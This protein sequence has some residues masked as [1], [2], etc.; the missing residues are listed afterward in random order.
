MSGRRLGILPERIPAAAAEAIGRGVGGLGITPN[1]ITLAGVAGSAAAAWLILEERLL[2]AGALYLGFSA[3]DFVDGAV[4]RAT[5]KATAYGA[6]L[7]AVMDRLGE[8][9]VLAACVWYFA[10]RGE[11]VQAGFGYA[12]LF[13]SVAVSYA[14]AR[15][16]ALGAPTR[17]GLFRRQERVLLLGVGLLANGLTVVI[18]VL[19]ALANA[20]ALQRWWIIGRA[21]R[22]QDR[23]AAAPR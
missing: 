13:G 21:L 5:G 23:E 12:A 4:A 19:A 18:I 20:T 11:S 10:E 16:E 2:I 15:G 8:A 14:R 9:L 3:L 7:D 6:L 22:A 1:M 17:E